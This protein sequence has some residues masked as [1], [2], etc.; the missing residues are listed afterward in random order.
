MIIFDT[1]YSSHVYQLAT[2]QS[3]DDS[4][5]VFWEPGL[6]NTRRNE[7]TRWGFSLDLFL[8][9][10]LIGTPDVLDLLFLPDSAYSIPLPQVIADNR[11]KFVTQTAHNNYANYAD[12]LK[13]SA[14]G[15]NYFAKKAAHAYIYL[16]SADAIATTGQPDFALNV[17][18]A[19]EI[20]SSIRGEWTKEQFAAAYD[21]L[22]GKVSAQKPELPPSANY[23][24]CE[25]IT[26]TLTGQAAPPSPSV[27]P[28]Q[29][30]E[31]AMAV[32]M[33]LNIASAVRKPCGTCSRAT[34][35]GS[36]K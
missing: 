7:P 25:Q 18:N 31:G 1:K 26:S 34:R 9:R 17:G 23:F 32:A 2:P 33:K 21:E 12:A 5:Y 15:N 29:T 10:A 20:V 22:R 4:R 30:L 8:S 19:R 6:L 16:H 27:T 13:L 3:D 36:K 14:T 11:S 24:L 35:E 28:P